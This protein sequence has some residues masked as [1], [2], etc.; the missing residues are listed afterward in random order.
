MLALWMVLGSTGLGDAAWSGQADEEDDLFDAPT[1][2]SKEQAERAIRKGVAYLKKVQKD[3]GSWGDVVGNRT[4]AGEA[5]QGRGEH[6][7][8]P[9]ALALYALLKCKVPTRDPIVRRG[10]AFLR[11]RHEEPGGSYETSAMLLATC[12]TANPYKTSSASRK[13]VD[14]GL[15]L[16]ERRTSDRLIETGGLE[17]R[18]R[19][20]HRITLASIKEVDDEVRR[21]MKTAYYLAQ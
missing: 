12:A 6:P 5:S 3:D 1:T 17:R 13:R 18:D 16:A 10:F 21:W 7:A 2:F 14:L 4:Y 9:T 11:E 15:A 20:T 19:I 8:G